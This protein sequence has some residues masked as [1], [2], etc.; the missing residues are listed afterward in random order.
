[1]PLV[2]SCQPDHFLFVAVQGESMR[3]SCPSKR[4]RRILEA[5]PYQ[6]FGQAR[7]ANYRSRSLSKIFTCWSPQVLLVLM[8]APG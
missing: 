6:T 2:I 5:V 1:M 3:W 4:Q 7:M 8:A